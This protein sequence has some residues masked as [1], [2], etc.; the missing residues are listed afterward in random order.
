MGL[1]TYPEYE[2]ACLSGRFTAPAQP[3]VVVVDLIRAFTSPSHPLGS[4]LGEVIAATSKLVDL[5][6][7]HS[8]PVLF[9]TIAYERDTGD[10]GRW[11]EKIPALGT[12]RQGSE[13]VEVD[14]RIPRRDDEPLIVKKGASAV[15]GTDLVARLRRAGVDGVVLC[16][17]STSG[18]VRATAVDLVQSGFGVV[19]P[20]EAVGDRSAA[21]HRASL[22]DLD[23]KYADVV[24][25]A[26]ARGLLLE[27]AGERS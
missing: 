20:R 9:T 17:A 15:F 26:W 1:E 5:A 3:A 23:A 10:L 16:G 22:I 7:R 12:L 24:S 25:L 27:W 21:A 4:E 6:R 14:G 18:C 19:I 8:N 11:V 2:R 13:W